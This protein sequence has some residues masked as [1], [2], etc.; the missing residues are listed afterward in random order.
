M[1]GAVASALDEART[2]LRM[3]TERGRTYYQILDQYLLAVICAEAE[4]YEEALEHARTYRELTSGIAGQLAE[5]QA[6][7]VE[8]YVACANTMERVG[9]S[10]CTA[11]VEMS[12]VGKGS[13]S[14]GDGTRR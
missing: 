7:L 5:F 2:A 9:T 14:S 12:G 8:A 13:R 11:D 3:A 4:S 10:A 1:R 6:L